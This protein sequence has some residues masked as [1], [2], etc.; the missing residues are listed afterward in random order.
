M[1][2]LCKAS[3]S[4]NDVRCSVCGQGFLIYW[5]RSCA[6]DR[7]ARTQIQQV[8]S[9]HHVGNGGPAAHPPVE[10]SVAVT[11]AAGYM[12]TLGAYA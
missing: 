8:L 3:D 12:E 11:P 4:V 1:Q 9:S 7:S 5:T 10:F 6:E 2:I